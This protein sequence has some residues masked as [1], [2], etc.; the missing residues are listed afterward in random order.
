MSKRNA[1]FGSSLTALRVALRLSKSELAARLRVSSKTIGRW[2]NDGEM[3]PLAQ[4]KHLASS[5]SDAPS[6]L[7]AA[8]VDALEL[9][10]SF[11]ASLAPSSPASSSAASVVDGALLALCERADVSPAR[12]RAVL[13]DFLRRIEQAGL[14]LASTRALLEPKT[15]TP[16]ARASRQR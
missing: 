5:F 14:S 12:M 11:A 9:D 10:P 4:R 15:V 2:E 6:H 16:A 7:H 3:P 13:A 8:L 1:D